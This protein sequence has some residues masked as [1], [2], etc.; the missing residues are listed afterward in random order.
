MI[1]MRD[2]LSSK[3]ANQVW[4]LIN[5]PIDHRSIGNNLVLNVKPKA[6]GSNKF[7][8]RFVPKGYTRR[9]GMNVPLQTKKKISSLYY[10]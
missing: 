6:N 7:N 8:A 1:A 4:E 3:A 2:E 5:L 10:D 9:E